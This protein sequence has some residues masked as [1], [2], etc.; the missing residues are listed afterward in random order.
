[1]HLIPRGAARRVLVLLLAVGALLA[2]PAVAFAPPD[3]GLTKTVDKAEAAPGD[4][5][6]YTLVIAQHGTHA[7]QPGTVTDVL[8]PF[9]TYVSSSGGCSAACAVITCPIG[10]VAVGASVT[11]TITVR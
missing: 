3:L 8:P 10:P 2:A 6:T 4:L 9:A 7:N 5:L 11:I 1:M